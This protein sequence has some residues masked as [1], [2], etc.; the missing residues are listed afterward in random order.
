[1]RSVILVLVFSAVTALGVD[2]FW[3]GDLMSETRVAQKWGKSPLD[4]KVFKSANEGQRAKMAFSLLNQQKE[5]K[6]KHVSEIRE[7]FGNP[8]GFYFSDVFPAYLI[9]TASTNKE[10]S[11]QIV[12][13]LNTE[14]RVEKI[15]VHKNCCD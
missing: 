7:I 15:I 6:G 2:H 11:W 3:K 10:E 8:D 9:Q 4:I 13:M 12:F 5:F 1:M 14:R